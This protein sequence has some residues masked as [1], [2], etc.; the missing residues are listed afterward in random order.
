L[1]EDAL[2]RSE[3]VEQMDDG[4]CT[5]DNVDDLNVLSLDRQTLKMTKRPVLAFVRRTSPQKLLKVATRSGRTITATEYHPFFTPEAAAV[6]TVRA[7]ELRPGTYIASPR[8]LPVESTKTH[9][10]VTASSGSSCEPE[11]VVVDN[12]L[13]T[14]STRTKPLNVVTKLTPEWGRFLGYI[15]SEGQNSS[16]T[17]QVRFVNG[18]EAVVKDYCS[19]ANALFGK[20]PTCKS[21]KNGSIDCLLF[22][23]LLCDFLEKN[24]GICRGGHSSTKTIPS[25]VFEAQDDVVWAF[26]SSLIEGDGCIRIDRSEESKPKA[27]LEYATASEE[28][29]RGL[30]T[31]L[32]RFGIRSLIRPKQKKATNSDGPVRTYYSVYVYGSENLKRLAAGLTLVSAKKDKLIEAT[33][34]HSSSA[35]SLDIIPNLESTFDTLWNK[36][37][38]SVK[39]EHP[40][41]GRLEVY[42]SNSCNPSRKGL[43]EAVAYIREN[44]AT[45][46]DSCE[47]LAEKLD[48]LAGSGVYWDEIESVEEVSGEEWVYDLCVEE[49]HNF[50]ANDFV[51]HNSNVVDAIR[52]VMGEQS[53]KH[54]RGGSMEDVIFNGADSR[55]P[56]GMAQV[57]MTFDNSDG[58]APAEYASY[59][60]IQIGRR[61]YRSGES[62]YFINKTPCRLKDIIDI[63][64]GTGVGTKA[65]SIVEQGRVDQIVSAK[66]EDRRMLIEEAAGISKFKNRKEAALRKMDSTKSNLARLDDILG[67]LGRQINS[68]NRQ[69]KKAERY[70]KI[71]GEL[72]GR[73]MVLAATKYRTLSSELT[74]LEKERQSFQENEVV[75]SSELSQ[76]ETELDERRLAISEK[77]RELDG[78]QQQLYA[79]KNAIK[80]AEAKITHK[81]QERESFTKQ[82]DSMAA[83]VEE[84][85]ERLKE[86]SE[87]L[88]RANTEKVEADIALAGSEDEVGGVEGEVES[89]RS[90]HGRFSQS[91][92]E[93]K[94]ILARAASSVSHQRARVEDLERRAIDIRGRLVKNQSEIDGIDERVK[95]LGKDVERQRDELEQKRQ[96]KLTLQE[97]YESSQATLMQQREGLADAESRFRKLSDEVGAKKSRLNS[98]KEL[99][100]NLEGFREGVRAVLKH[101][102]ETQEEFKGILCTVNE[103]VETE[104]KY[105][106]ALSAVLGERLQYVVVKSHEEG[107]GAIDYL[108]GAACGR[109]SFIP[110]NVRLT[111]DESPTPTGEGVIGPMS[112]LVQFSDEYRPIGKYLVGDVV[113]V[114]NLSRALNM[115]GEGTTTKTFVTLDGEVV[116]PAGV[117]TGGEGGDLEEHLVTQKRRMQ[118]LEEDIAALSSE[119]T[120]AEGEVGKFRERVKSLEEGLEN[121]TRS[122]HGEEIR[123]VSQERD[124]VRLEDDLSRYSQERDRLSVEIA[125]LTEELGEVERERDDLVNSVSG[126]ETQEREAKE[127]L[128]DAEVK[129]GTLNGELGVKEKRF[130]DL[131]VKLAQASEREAAITREVDGL[132]STKVHSIVTV[133]RRLAE[134]T[135]NNQRSAILLREVD[136]L[137]E[138]L[139]LNIKAVDGLEQ[140]RVSISENYQ[141]ES[142]ELRQRELDIRE[143]RKQHKETSNQAHSADIAFTEQ[144]GQV[145]FLISNMRERYRVEIV[146]VHGEYPTPE[147][148]DFEGEEKTVTDLKERVEK[149]GSV[150]V[151]AITEYE[152]M[153]QRYDFLKRQRD[154]LGLSMDNLSKAIAR[155]NRTSRQRFRSTYELV[156]AKFQE[157]FP[158]LFR[159]GK[160]RLLLTDEDNILETGVEIVAQPP[161]KKLQSITLLSG[162]EKALTAVALIFSIFLIKPSPFCLLDEVDAPLDDAN[163]DR[164]NDL[165]RSM[166][167]HSQFILITHNKRT[168]ELADLLYGV[169]MEE[170]GVSKIVSVRLNQGD[171]ESDVA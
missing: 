118:E 4:E 14:G 9:F 83:E 47:S 25:A 22:S 95:A 42:R 103:V 11:S 63:F 99:R 161:G 140:S 29:A 40:I 111:P 121:L 67:E 59:S 41:R 89:L 64:L 84:L 88:D 145:D 18:D 162:G 154:D 91:V 129:L 171:I 23:S 168:M 160:A 113:L 112:D 30:S 147:G 74:R 159:G 141:R 122:G 105:E 82:N 124:V 34:V 5:Y 3:S 155:I 80:L 6:R 36:A 94:L 163:I 19:T 153:S 27:Y 32:L 26:L 51:I 137:G 169:T 127:R 144:R 125:A 92:E 101:S 54:L 123:I 142:E 37:G 110:I 156:D 136:G 28:L 50:V 104:P 10:V 61:L 87:Q 49:D 8:H 75:Q 78:V 69:V 20:E 167:P 97:E 13:V 117:V 46:E 81:T 72:K 164:F 66:P 139:D 115:W 106:R 102:R 17:D 12:M 57:F 152:E 149:I 56:M 114:D 16:W 132:L 77:E 96:L 31:V 158:R 157:V 100:E 108:K 150:N 98:L 48:M 119:L 55:Q 60:E 143:L 53:A 93:D 166:T 52:W 134:I 7:D 2:E 1:V 116:D 70:Q 65:Y 107:V 71:A 86:I 15:I 146:Q 58:C 128:A 165:I 62:E 85:K 151:D 24:F 33:A 39:K 21:Y 90:E 35:A 170:A 45:W 109:S 68:L 44:A 73:E 79:T 38:A 43:S 76:Y 135:E 126:S 120:R 133:D 130:F 131:K 138:E 148:Y